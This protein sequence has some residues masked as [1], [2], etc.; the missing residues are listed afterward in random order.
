MYGGACSSAPGNR[1]LPSRVRP[2]KGAN[3]TELPA[4]R[5]LTLPRDA[6]AD[7]RHHRSHNRAPLLSVSASCPPPRFGRPQILAFILER[8][9]RPEILAF[10][11]GCADL[12]AML[13]PTTDRWLGVHAAAKAGARF[14]PGSAGRRVLEAAIDAYIAR[15]EQLI[16]EPGRRTA[17]VMGAYGLGCKFFGP[18][19]YG[20][21]EQ[22]G[23]WVRGRPAVVPPPA[24]DAGVLGGALAGARS[25]AWSAY[26]KRGY[27]VTPRPSHQAGQDKDVFDSQK[28]AFLAGIGKDHAE[29]V[30]GLTCSFGRVALG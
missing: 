2:T 26:L 27:T 17:S 4:G 9:G 20:V 14:P 28:T 11:L 5:S 21:L 10:I 1:L 8:F 22:V 16:P 15:M 3:L 25:P 18:G 23:R 29:A 13:V 7:E 12:E 19:A 30:Q 24:H 6:G